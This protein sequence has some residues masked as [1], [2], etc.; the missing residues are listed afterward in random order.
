MFHRIQLYIWFR[1]LLFI[2]I[3]RMIL[4]LDTLLGSILYIIRFPLR[5]YTDVL[6]FYYR[7]WM[8]LCWWI[9]VFYTFFSSFTY[10]KYQ[11]NNTLCLTKTHATKLPRH[12]G[13]FLY[14][15]AS[16][17]NI[18]IIPTMTFFAQITKV[19][20]IYLYINGKLFSFYFRCTSILQK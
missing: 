17:L 3:S 1:K 14:K 20:R 12:V 5:E 13:V 2:F 19:L 4:W 15:R 18:L 6:H 8:E 11:E 7:N 9:L 10:I 16:A